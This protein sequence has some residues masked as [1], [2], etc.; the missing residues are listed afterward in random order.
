MITLKPLPT[1]GPGELEA[2]DWKLVEFSAKSNNEVALAAMALY[3]CLNL[4]LDELVTEFNEILK[5]DRVN[6]HKWYRSFRLRKRI[7]ELIHQR[8]DLL[9][10]DFQMEKKRGLILFQKSMIEVSQTN[11]N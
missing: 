4:E 7:M 1:I 9:Y 3:R 2:S 5:S 8:K 6:L 10:I 11:K